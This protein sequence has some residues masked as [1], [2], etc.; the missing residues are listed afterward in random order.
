MDSDERARWHVPEP[1][2]QGDAL[3]DLHD[4]KGTSWIKDPVRGYW[5]DCCDK[6]RPAEKRVD[7]PAAVP[8]PFREAFDLPATPDTSPKPPAPPGPVAPPRSGSDEAA[9]A[10]H[11]LMTFLRSLLPPEDPQ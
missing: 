6:H 2:Y 3:T 8:A 5:P 7:S 4:G 1:L 9:G 10:L 11:G